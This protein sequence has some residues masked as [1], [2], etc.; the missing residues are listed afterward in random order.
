MKIDIDDALIL[1]GGRIHVRPDAWPE[2]PEGWRGYLR[3]VTNGKLRHFEAGEFI[4]PA[5][6]GMSLPPRA[7]WPNLA[8]CALAAD[9]F[10]E[11]AGVPVRV[12]YGYRNPELNARRGGAPRSD[13]LTAS[14]VDL[15]CLGD[16]AEAAT[17]KARDR[18]VEA[19]W[20]LPGL[21]V[22]IGEGKTKTHLGI[23]S[24]GGRRR[25]KY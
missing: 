19:L 14:A 12:R 4:M 22:S 13:H 8:V 17:Q 24:P 3:T 11:Q 7:L 5:S 20:R 16:H 18:W 10:R 9:E 25:W 2:D 23:L 6:G 1:F 15:Q 21:G